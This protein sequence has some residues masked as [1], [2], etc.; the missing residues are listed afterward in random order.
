M[1]LGADVNLP[2]LARRLR[3]HTAADCVAVCTEAA[4]RCASE[5]VAAAEAAAAAEE[6]GANACPGELGHVLASREFVEG[7]RVEARH[8]EAAAAVLGPAVLRGVSPEVPEVAWEDV[9]GLQVG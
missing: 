6:W 2:T 3:G 1:P 7:L 5:A 9:G 8:L 4:L